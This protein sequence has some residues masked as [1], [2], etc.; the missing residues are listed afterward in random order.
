[1][2]AL[3]TSLSA[4]EKYEE[5]KKE[6]DIIT[7]QKRKDGLKNLT[8]NINNRLIYFKDELGICYSFSFIRNSAGDETPVLTTVPCEVVEKSP[9][10]V[11]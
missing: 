6:L 11:K 3:L 7:Q 5:L 9:K 8:S 1:M 4:C 2:A 10:F